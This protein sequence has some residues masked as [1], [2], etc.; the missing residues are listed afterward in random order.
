MIK[1]ELMLMRHGKSDWSV[2]R[3]DFERP[4]NKRGRRN[5]TR[6]GLRMVEQ[7]T[8]PDR[9]ICS[10]A[11]RAMQT[12]R[13]VC[14]AIGFPYSSIQPEPRLYEADIDE[15]MDV[16]CELKPKH[17]RVL[18]IGHNPG[19][20][21][22]LLY[23]CPTVDVP[24]DGKLLPTAA[25]ARLLIYDD[26]PDLAQDMARLQS[27]TRPKSLSETFPF[28]TADGVEYRERPAYFYLQS[29]A[30]PYRRMES[31]IQVLLVSSRTNDAWTI[32]KG[33]LQKN[34]T[35]AESAQQEAFEEAG[36][37]VHYQDKPSG[38]CYYKKWGA[39]C[40]LDVY[41]M[42]VDELVEAS[43]WPESYR[44]RQW[45]EVGEIAGFVNEPEL[46]KVITQLVN[47]LM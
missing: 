39:P 9:L 28:P 4:L 19:L 2:D 14:D 44:S 33:I 32:P 12:A 24:D 26:W 47:E 38:R 17:R 43:R 34:M 18:M 42:E 25:L 36:A 35:A 16:V 41:P 7:D 46:V 6:M 21:H 23:L 1:H 8:L 13:R 5:A 40:E 27:I 20:E 30:I 31:R 11:T 22:L 10:P 15:L 45:V 37:I 29:G 3:P